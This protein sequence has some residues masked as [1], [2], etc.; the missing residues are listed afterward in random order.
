VL[1]DIISLSAP[2][3]CAV[4]ERAPALTDTPESR[5]QLRTFSA[6]TGIPFDDLLARTNPPDP[7]TVLTA[8]GWQS[9]NTTIDDLEQRYARSLQRDRSEPQPDSQRG[10]FVTARLS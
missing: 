2:G 4:I 1:D 10:G 9:L 7:A 8:A 6:A 3:S 5:E